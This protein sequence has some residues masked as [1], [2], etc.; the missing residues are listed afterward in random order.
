MQNQI[1]DN[2]G[3][4]CSAGFPRLHD[5]MTGSFQPLSQGGEQSGLPSAFTTLQSYEASSVHD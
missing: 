5:S 1:P 3:E 2:F 4:L